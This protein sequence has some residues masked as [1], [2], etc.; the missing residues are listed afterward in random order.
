MPDLSGP[1]FPQKSERVHVEYNPEAIEIRNMRGIK[2][3]AHEA[4]KYI[5][6]W[7]KTDD[8]NLGD[9]QQHYAYQDIVLEFHKEKIKVTMGEQT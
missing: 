8:D 7:D 5:I 9:I 1:E 2:E 6:M 4:R 3:R